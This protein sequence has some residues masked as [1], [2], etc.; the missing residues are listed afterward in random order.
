MGILDPKHTTNSIST[1]AHSTSGSRWLGAVLL[2][3]PMAFATN[4]IALATDLNFQLFNNTSAT[5]MELYMSPTDLDD[6]EEDILG[7]NVLAPQER[8]NV[9][10]ADGRETC[11]YDILG[12]FDDDEQVEDYQVDLC[13][14]ES[15]SFTEN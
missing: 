1:M 5:L 7:P 3:I 2:S 6:W 13:E 10:I 9:T 4:A 11:M 12:I 8:G 15:Y 14:L